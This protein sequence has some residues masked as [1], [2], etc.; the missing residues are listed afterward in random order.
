M[1]EQ[2]FRK[3]SIEKVSSPEQLNEYI[4][5]SNPGVWMVLAAIVILLI[6]VC[7]WGILGHLDT[8]VTTVAVVENSEIILYIKEVDIE[9]IKEG[10]KVM[11]G[12]KECEIADIVAQP[13]AV[14]DD[15][16]EYAL[17][18]GNLQKGE[19]VYPVAANGESE[20]GIHSADIVVESISPMSFV[21]N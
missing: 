21:I 12:N 5:V 4:R 10:M 20:D 3:K 8:T 7:I 13:V 11:I 17:H 18:I 9:Q 19:W 16:P 15:F 14:G 6:G 2:L 1:N